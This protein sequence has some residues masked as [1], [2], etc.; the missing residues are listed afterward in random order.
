MGV[1][2]GLLENIVFTSEWAKS[3]TKLQV[4]ISM[5]TKPNNDLLNVWL[6]GFI[7]FNN[8]GL[9]RVISQTSS[10]SR[11]VVDYLTF[12]NIY[13]HKILPAVSDIGSITVSVY[14]DNLSIIFG[15]CN[16][17]TCLFLNDV[18]LLDLE[19]INI[20]IHAKVKLVGYNQ[21][22]QNILVRELRND[23]AV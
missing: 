3:M 20:A 16:N 11:I 6:M 4:K 5:D 9:E 14:K 23:L 15:N 21:H 22:M 18:R 19:N 1:M 17:I 12:R 7:G 13:F 8:V 10:T 2:L